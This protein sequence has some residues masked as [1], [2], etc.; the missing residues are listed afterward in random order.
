MV[1]I[2]NEVDKGEKEMTKQID[3]R[4]LEC[5]DYGDSRLNSFHYFLQTGVVR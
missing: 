1:S 5:A 3:Y 2:E 4:D